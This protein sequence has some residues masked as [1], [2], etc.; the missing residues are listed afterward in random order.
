MAAAKE[1]AEPRRDERRGI[2]E[3]PR[4]RY[5]GPRFERCGRLAELTR[6]GGSQIL[7]SGSGGLGQAP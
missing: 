3:H 7:D 1:R 5:H 2:E 6:F 4:R